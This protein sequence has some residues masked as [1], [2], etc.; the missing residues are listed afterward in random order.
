MKKK[1]K[2]NKFQLFCFKIGHFMKKKINKKD[3]AITRYPFSS[4]TKGKAPS[5]Y[6]RNNSI[7]TLSK[8]T[9]P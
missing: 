9:T 4:Q 5:L 3:W 2:K 6:K 7:K 8:K 1:N